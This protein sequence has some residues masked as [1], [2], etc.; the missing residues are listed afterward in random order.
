MTPV[1]VPLPWVSLWERHVENRSATRTDPGR[2]GGTP[3]RGQEVDTPRR[4]G[5][6]NQEY[7]VETRNTLLVGK[8]PPGH[9]SSSRGVPH[10]VPSPRGQKRKSAPGPGSGHSR[11]L[12]SFRGVPGGACDVDDATRQV[13]PR[14]TGERTPTFRDV[15]PVTHWSPVTVSG[16]YGWGVR[17]VRVPTTGEDP[18]PSNDGGPGG[19]RSGPLSDERFQSRTTVGCHQRVRVPWTTPHRK[20][21]ATK[22]GR[23]GD[24]GGG[25]G[26][27]LE[28]RTDGDRK[29]VV[30]GQTAGPFVMSGLG[31][32][33]VVSPQGRAGLVVGEGEGRGL[34]RPG[35]PRVEGT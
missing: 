30:E 13:G 14:K 17:G 9:G 6:S 4:R 15:L 1:L 20:T 33:G 3:P 2:G 11:G 12:S 21:W 23:S 32:V 18:S 8:V 5:R 27:V 28:W 16:V 35:A 31:A 24:R 25:R 7:Y 10:G 29:R 26:G 19:G 34:G 22:R